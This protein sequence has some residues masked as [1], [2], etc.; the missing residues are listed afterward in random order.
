[1]LIH[2]RPLRPV[3]LAGVAVL[4]PAAAVIVLG[5]VL[6]V[7]TSRRAHHD[8]ESRC[9]EL[10]DATVREFESR[11]GWLKDHLEK[12]L[13]Q[14]D[15]W[16]EILSDC[17]PCFDLT[18]AALTVPWTVHDGPPS[19]PEIPNDPEGTPDWTLFIPEIERLEYQ[20][21]DPRKAAE[22]YAQL[23]TASTSP[24]MRARFE[25]LRA[26]A[27]RRAG[28]FAG[29]A[30]A[31]QALPPT[32]GSWS[33][34]GI[35]IEA[36]ARLERA[37][38]LQ[39]LDDPVRARDEA[40]TLLQDLANHRVPL[41]AGRAA[42]HLRETLAQL[43]DLV[44]PADLAELTRSGA[45]SQQRLAR[46]DHAEVV[47]RALFTLERSEW[48]CGEVDEGSSLVFV[49]CADD[50]LRCASVVLE[51][52][53][54]ARHLEGELP[55]PGYH[56]RLERESRADSPTAT[57]LQAV[58]PLQGVP[59]S[60]RV[61]VIADGDRVSQRARPWQLAIL[62]GT[63]VIALT[64]LWSALLAMRSVRRKLELAQV[65][66]GLVASI[67]HEL[68]TPLTSILVNAE[69]LEDPR[70][71]PPA[72]QR[73]LRRIH[74]SAT[75]LRALV[76]RVLEFARRE[77]PGVPQLRIEEDPATLVAC[78]IEEMSEL[79]KGHEVR[80]EVAQGLPKVKVDRD[81]FVQVLVSLL[82]NS[83]KYAGE[84]AP[85]AVRARAS[86]SDFVEL[87]VED[88]GSGVPQAELGLLFEPFFRSGQSAEKVFGAGLGLAIAKRVVEAHQG[89]IEAELA[90][91]FVPSSGLRVVIRL[92]ACPHS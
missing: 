1:M 39:R 3:I 5:A 77:Q 79:L 37:R 21:Q 25:L 65:R 10:A 27:L 85:I 2:K 59:P 78:A 29:A 71:E 33:L 48:F 56:V 8:V 15:A 86:G 91:P 34:D 62:A 42:A 68:R 26:G 70:V 31:L 73:Y 81:A 75:R 9:Q 13:A 82:D 67:S 47:S 45:L 80:C 83:V 17:G 20:L 89:T 90:T 4:I 50:G 36:S 58:L 35:P 63:A 28:D 6:W 16:M 64:S 74:D 14:S 84:K 40:L 18:R 57:E 22:R 49:K 41:P 7:E 51:T 12:G 23:A 30:D 55:V 72:R 32:Y 60:W 19:A 92:P 43:E 87:E 44:D 24:R 54:L 53:D 76:Q 61:R 69:L 66:S 11:A 52:D 46:L 88:R 38:L